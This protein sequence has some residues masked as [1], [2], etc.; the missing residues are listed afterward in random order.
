M[1]IPTILTLST[2][3]TSSFAATLHFLI[4][5][6]QSLPDPSVLP[7]TTHIT[8]TTTGH[9][10]TSPIRI[11]NDFVVRN[12]TNGQSYLVETYATGWN[13]A[14]LRVDVSADGKIVEAWV[15]FRGNEWDN[16]GE[17]IPKSLNGEILLQQF[18]PAGSYYVKREGFNPMK[19]LS[20]PMILIAGVSLFALVLI[21]KIMDNM[22]PEL[23]AEFEKEQKKTMA[24]FG[25]GGPDLAGML[26]GAKAG[27]PSV[28]APAA[29]GVKERK[30]KGGR[31]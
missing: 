10:Y 23:K 25:G 19:L 18:A 8:L 1:K 29:A 15:T 4:P 27:G 26:S 22:D 20:N 13:F 7:P 17:R 21:P 6:T 3:A 24:A 9:S 31:R 11:N 30:G 16:K 2:F 14:P 5:P 28:V 12:V